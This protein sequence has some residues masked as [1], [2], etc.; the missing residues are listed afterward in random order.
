MKF[1]DLRN[2][3]AMNTQEDDVRRHDELL[4]F[5]DVVSF[6][7]HFWPF[8]ASTAA[9]CTILGLLYVLTA[10]PSYTAVAELLIETNQQAT[11]TITTPEAVVSLDT[12]QIES[13]I[14]LLNSEQIVSR[15][16]KIL[17][18]EGGGAVSAAKPAAGASA[19]AE[20]S[21]LSRLFFGPPPAKTA[22]N[23]NKRLQALV[24]QIQGDLSVKRVGLSYVLELS[25]RDI[26]PK[27]AAEVVNALGDAYVQ[28]KIEGR[29]T[30]ARRS[31]M[32]LEARIEEIR[33]LMNEAA[34]DVQE[35]KARRDYRLADR[36][37]P[38][39]RDLGLDFLPKSSNQPDA[40]VTSP[41]G[42][43]KPDATAPVTPDTTT[44]KPE[45][46]DSGRSTGAQE[47]PT[48]EEL[49]SR[50]L[51]YRKI[52]ES[53]LQAYTDTVQRQSFPGTASRVISRAEPPKRQSSPKRGL[54]LL[55]SLVLGS[56]LGFGISLIRTA[57]DETV[58]S[59]NQLMRQIGAP[60]LGEIDNT[61]WMARLPI[62]GRGFRRHGRR[63]EDAFLVLR[64]PHSLA[65][66]QLVKSAASINDAAHASGTNVI[67]IMGISR[68]VDASA[69]CSNIALLNAR[70]GKR[71]LLI[72]TEPGRANLTAAYAPQLSF[73]LKDVVAG[74]INPENAVVA[75]GKDPLLSLLLIGSSEK[76]EFWSNEHL[77][78]LRQVIS[79]LRAQYDTIFVH[80]PPFS[81]ADMALRA[82]DGLVI[83][84]EMWR[85]K[86]SSLEEVASRMRIGDHALLGVVVANLA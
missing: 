24:S 51:T 43:A 38:S 8:I 33:R 71:T 32:W 68:D 52:Y 25:Y 1:D 3:Q 57:F 23:E 5:S 9:V 16:A 61:S 26:D 47:A 39:N 77:E 44:A 62:I 12:P 42:P 81:N 83:V 58:R 54:T 72:E 49:D 76:P 50:A 69:V 36:P 64:R 6:F 80:L 22:D 59:S 27:R 86:V 7:K 48:L 45:A 65:A 67:G 53:Y 40:A 79:G 35:F 55:G 30:A 46:K 73:D 63:T 2:V 18:T 10:T 31:G 14:V 41:D 74:G 60:L 70:A 78:K 20:Q 84:G 21:W 29:A 34:L 56:L 82:A 17:E 4:S 66:R 15:A 11:P 85:T 19:P 13:E 37:A 75:F 28:D